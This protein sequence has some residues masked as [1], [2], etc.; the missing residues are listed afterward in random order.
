[1]EI[2][3]S[4]ND[5][6]CIFSQHLNLNRTSYNR[7]PILFKPFALQFVNLKLANLLKEMRS[8]MR[9]PKLSR[10]IRND[11]IQV[12]ILCSTISEFKYLDF[13]F[14]FD[15]MLLEMCSNNFVQIVR[16]MAF[17][18]LLNRRNIGLKGYIFRILNRQIL[19]P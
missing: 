8:K 16:F 1:M 5:F 4:H 2:I 13:V 10:R 14:V 9:R 7:F 18:T 6:V 17:N 19:I 15:S 3:P 12:R 11:Q